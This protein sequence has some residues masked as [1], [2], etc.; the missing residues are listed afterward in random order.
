MYDIAKSWEE[1]FGAEIIDISHDTIDFRLTREISEE[2]I[3]LLIQECRNHYADAYC[4]GGYEE[5]RKI[6]K[7]KSEFYIWWD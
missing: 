1:R 3:D 6:I 4:T 2:E 5:L 7:D